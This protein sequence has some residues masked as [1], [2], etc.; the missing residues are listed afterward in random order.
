MKL[1]RKSMRKVATFF[2]ASILCLAGVAV[3]RYYHS[4]ETSNNPDDPASFLSRDDVEVLRQI[5]W[6]R[7]KGWFYFQIQGRRKVSVEVLASSE[8]P[9]AVKTAIQEV[10]PFLKKFEHLDLRLGNSD[11]LKEDL[12]L[13]LELHNVEQL[14]VNG[15]QV[16][17]KDI[18]WLAK[19]LGCQRVQSTRWGYEFT[20]YPFSIRRH[21]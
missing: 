13:F 11:L 5:S 7:G 2:A 17:D 10:V 18:E 20:L 21:E 6:L 1:R 12:D 15:P 3:W 4:V 19:E 8:S 16:S 14:Y 9:V